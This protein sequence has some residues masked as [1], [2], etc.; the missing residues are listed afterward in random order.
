MDSELK[1]L[2]S[3]PLVSIVDPTQE[4]DVQTAIAVLPSLHVLVASAFDNDPDIIYVR[5]EDELL[6][7]SMNQLHMLHV[8]NKR[9]F[10]ERR[11]LYRALWDISP[12]KRARQPIPLS[13]RR[14]FSESMA[15]LKAKNL[16][17]QSTEE[18]GWYFITVLG[19][20]VYRVI[21]D[22]FDEVHQ[23]IRRTF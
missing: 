18:R 4:R 17:Y 7:I 8:L 13:I 14:S 21:M 5:V 6:A 20:E 12:D 9:G 23:I 16:V 19:N 10:E 1:R 11:E 2:L 15:R 22:W 3:L